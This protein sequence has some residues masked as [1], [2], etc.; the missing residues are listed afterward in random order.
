MSMRLL[1]LG[2]KCQGLSQSSQE[3]S[4]VCALLLLCLPLVPHSFKFFQNYFVFRVRDWFLE[5]FSQCS[6]STFSFRHSL[7]SL[8]T[9]SFSM[10]LSHTQQ[11]A[12]VICYSVISSLVLGSGWRCFSVGLVQP[13]SWA[14][15][16]FLGLCSGSFSVTLLLLTGKGSPTFWA[17]GT[18]LPLPQGQNV[19]CVLS[20]AAMVLHLCL[21]HDRVCF[22]K[23]LFHRRDREEQSGSSLVLFLQQLL[24]PFPNLH[25]NGDF[26]QSLALSPSLI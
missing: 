19:F 14:G 22:L 4:W 20:P 23:L 6:C 21:E 8:E 13:Q 10:L 24:F 9:Q 5:D 16:L 26:L 11:Q 25:H 17:Q 18:F 15:T 3:L 12:A 1:L 7:S 2:I